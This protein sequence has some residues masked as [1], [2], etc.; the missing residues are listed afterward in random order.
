MITSCNLGCNGFHI[1]RIDP[2]TFSVEQDF[3]LS[4]VGIGLLTP[5]GRTMQVSE[6]GRMMWV[7]VTNSLDSTFGLREYRLC[8]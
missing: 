4:E 8:S 1:I 7:I 5:G 3:H 2:L 6:D